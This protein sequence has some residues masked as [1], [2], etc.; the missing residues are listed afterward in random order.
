MVNDNLKIIIVNGRPQ[1]GKTTF[2]KFCKEK[3]GF[4]CEIISTIDIIKTMARVGGWNGEKTPE[5]RKLLSD[6][7]D[8]WTQYNDLSFNTVKNFI[9][10]WECELE[11]YHVNSVPHIVFVDSREPEEIQKFREELGAIAVLVRRP[12]VE[13]EESSN[14]ADENVFRC[15]YDYELWNTGTLDNLEE[16]AKNFINLIFDKNVV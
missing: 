13:D 5:A 6:L 10:Q 8:L 15:R 4:F 7:K 2:E 16:I 12:D 14:H 9:Q 11:D 3:L 1:C